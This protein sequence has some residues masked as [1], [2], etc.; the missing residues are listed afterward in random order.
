MIKVTSYEQLKKLLISDDVVLVY[1]SADSCSVC[2]ADMPVIEKIANE[3]NIPMVWVEIDKAMEISGQ[4]S[5][6]SVPAVLLFYRQ[7]EYHRQA[8]FI[9]F[10]ELKK[11]VS[12]IIQT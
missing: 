7:K 4:L 2:R 10:Y 12:E 9:D 1:C 11:R 6:F 5:V 8:H 3:F